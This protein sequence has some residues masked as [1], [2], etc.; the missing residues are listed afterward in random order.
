[1]ARPRLQHRSATVATPPVLTKPVPFYPAHL[2]DPE[3]QFLLDHLDESP[4]VALQGEL[5]TGVNP[6]AIEHALQPIHDLEQLRIHRGLV[7]AGYDA[8]RDVII[9]YQAWQKLSLDSQ[10]LGGPRFPSMHTW[11]SQGTMTKG[12]P[13]SDSYDL[14]RHEILDDGS[15]RPLFLEDLRR[16]II[17]KQGP[18]LPWVRRS[19]QDMALDAVEHDDVKGLLSC[20][21]CGHTVTYAAGGGRAKLNMARGK[22]ARHLK[23]TRSEPN[24]HQALYRREFP[25]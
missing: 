2:S 20:S 16:P 8:V 9:R 6:V 7:W 18:R 21:I 13:G 23:S 3:L 19:E 1:M 5:P 22:M 10:A 4:L 25:K 17:A 15:R 11:D 12:T 24:R 14:V